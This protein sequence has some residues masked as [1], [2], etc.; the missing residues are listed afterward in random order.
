[1]D[2]GND[3]KCS[4]ERT[5]LKIIRWKQ[6]LESEIAEVLVTTWQTSNLAC[7]EQ[8]YLIVA[9]AHIDMTCFLIDTN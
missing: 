9:A 8:G 1:M 6:K 3:L 7:R 2:D 5:A 4:R